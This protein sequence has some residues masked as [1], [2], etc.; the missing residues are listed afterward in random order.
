MGM[1][2]NYKAQVMTDTI[3]ETIP[4][5]PF[6]MLN[7]FLVV[8]KGKALLVDTG[9]PNSKMKIEKA[10]SKHKLDW[11]NLHLT[12][13]TH[14]HIDHSGSAA[15][16]R[17]LSQ[18][19]ILAH[20]DEVQYCLGRPPVLRPTGTFGRLF[21][22]TGA[23]QQPFD[24]FTPDRI[25]ETDTLNL[26]EYGFPARVLHTPG[27]TQG[28]VSILL[29]AGRVIAGDLTASGILL[30]GIVMRNRPKQPPFEEDTST[31]IASL[32][33]LLSRGCEQFFLGHGGPLT[34]AVIKK[35]IEILRKK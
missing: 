23:I 9:L 35:H 34:A 22:K 3:V 11:S 29:E 26:D 27:H 25:M 18:G 21:Q 33:D 24:Y 17:S 5:L 2:Q 19:D 20:Q 16:I 4:I 13:L 12:I 30:G 14:A 7:A 31:V 10:L 1:S 15:E 28:S 32:E 8:N 6:G